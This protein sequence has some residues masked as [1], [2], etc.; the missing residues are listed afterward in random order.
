MRIAVVFDWMEPGW[1]D[2]DFKQALEAADSEV[3][4]AEYEIAEALIENGHDVFLIGFHDNLRHLLDRLEEI[5]PDLAPS[6][7]RTLR[8]I[9]DQQSFMRRFLTTILGVFAGSALVLAMRDMEWSDWG[10]PPTGR[11]IGPLPWTASAWPR[12]AI[13]SNRC[14]RAVVSS[15]VGLGR[16]G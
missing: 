10:R 5:D 15:W 14:W 4:E 2:A 1:E 12:R 11:G 9:V 6:D 8:A 3:A 7:I 13:A 16:S